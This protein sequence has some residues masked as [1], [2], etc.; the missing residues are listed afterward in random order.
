MRQIAEACL[1]APV[2]NVVINVPA[3]FS[4]FQRKATK[5]AGAIAGLNVI[6]IINEPTAAAIAYDKVFE[7]KATTG[8]NHLGGEDFD[9]KIANYFVQEFKRKNK[10]DISRNPKAS[11]RLKNA[12]ERAKRT[13]SFTYVTVTELDALHQG[14]ELYTSLSRAKFEEL[15]MELF[16]VYGNSK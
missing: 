14:I 1:E 15:H 7:V 8:N 6:R 9:N 2:N 3:Y 11:R 5:D 12:C 13:L 4:D 10:V 16:R